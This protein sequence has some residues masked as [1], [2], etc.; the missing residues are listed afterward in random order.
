[1]NEYKT[2]FVNEIFLVNSQ[3]NPMAPSGN[4]PGTPL[5]KVAANTAI[6]ERIKLK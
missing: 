4:N 6:P 5:H 2:A 3:Y 1:M